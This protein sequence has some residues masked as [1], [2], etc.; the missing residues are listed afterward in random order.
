M[1]TNTIDDAEIAK[2]EAMAAEWWDETGK[3]K[4]LHMMNPVRLDYIT[5]H[6]AAH[7]GRDLSADR[8]FEGLRL[9]DIGCGGGLLCEPMAR[10]GATVVGVDAAP[11]NIPVARIHAEQSGLAIDYRVGTAEALAAAGEQFD[12][13]LNM[14]VVE[15]VA[16]P[17]GYLDACAALLKPDG[18]HLCSTINRNPK[19]FALAIVGA[20][21]VMRWLPKG[22]HEWAKFITPDEL[23][24]LLEK[25]GLTPVD[26]TGYVFNPL[27]FRWSMSEKDLSVNYVTAA[28]K[29]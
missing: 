28:V 2:F 1:P 20:E 26:R 3:F 17:Q 25:A 23:F 15:H 16:D 6:V 24:A 13:V 11:R 14:E 8:P 12:V 27:T 10:L 4:P 19:S 7:F 21:W 18:L 5:R 29:P 9:L 22:T